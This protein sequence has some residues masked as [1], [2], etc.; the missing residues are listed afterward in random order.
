[1]FPHPTATSVLGTALHA[2]L[3]T[4]L[5][6]AALPLLA[7]TVPGGTATFRA[8]AFQRVWWLGLGWSLAEVT[9]G[10][11]Q[12]Y[13]TLE[14]YRDVLVPE[15]NAHELV[16]SATSA[17]P[18]TQ[19]KTNESGRDSP[20]PVV[21]TRL[22]VYSVYVALYGYVAK[23][24]MTD[25]RLMPEEPRLVSK[26]NKGHIFH[27][28]RFQIIKKLLDRITTSSVSSTEKPRP[29]NRIRITRCSL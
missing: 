13:E 5:R 26:S 28:V 14:L 7:L 3:R 21:H 25:E 19:P 11:V 17:W 27:T 6:T 24:E 22:V 1:L 8:P 4:A 2:V 16:A 29:P 12:W 9:A 20:S 18:A 23:R 10:I 15:S